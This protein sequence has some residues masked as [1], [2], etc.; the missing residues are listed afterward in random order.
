MMNKSRK[1]QVTSNSIMEK[2]VQSL[3]LKILPLFLLAFITAS[4]APINIASGLL[5]VTPA[6]N[7]DRVIATKTARG[8][9][10]GF[11]VGDYTHAVI[12]LQN[13][14]EESYYIGGTGVDYF[15]ALHKGEPLVITYQVVDSYIPEAGGKMRIERISAARAGKETSAGW[16]KKTRAKY[17]VSQIEKKYGGLVEKYRLNP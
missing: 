8:T 3:K 10:K 12:N 17:S 15:L 14:K 7:R 11:E 16:W 4:A 13:G 1:I 5:M 6:Q 9:L 2:F